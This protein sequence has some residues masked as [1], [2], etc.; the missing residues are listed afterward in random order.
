MRITSL[1]P[2]ALKVAGLFF[3]GTVNSAIGTNEEIDMS[4]KTYLLNVCFSP[5]CYSVNYSAADPGLAERLREGA[6]REYQENLTAL[7]A[8]LV[9]A[10]VC[11]G[12]YT[13]PKYNAFWSNH[14]YL[15]SNVKAAA[16]VAEPFGEVYVS[17]PDGGR[18]YL[19]ESYR[20]V[21]T[22]LF[23]DVTAAER[24][25][26]LERY[27]ARGRLEYLFSVAEAP[28]H[29]ALLEALTA[30]VNK[31]STIKQLAMVRDRIEFHRKAHPE[32]QWTGAPRVRPF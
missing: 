3:R 22:W 1:A 25:F 32:W 21:P 15:V 27:H 16:L 29:V 28:E 12:T 24:A 13:Q 2:A 17:K 18:H 20:A 31:A 11:D 19:F 4:K 8:A 6:K 10:D 26:N 5:R 30:N 9:A 23:R 7:S 14:E